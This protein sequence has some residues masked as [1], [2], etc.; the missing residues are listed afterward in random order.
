MH[1]YF[2]LTIGSFIVQIFKKILK[3]DPELLGCA[4]FW[5]KMVHLAQTIFF[6]G[7]VINI[8]FIYL[9]VPFIVQ[10]FKNIL[11]AN[12]EL[13]GCAIFGPKWPNCP[14]R[15]FFRKPVNKNIHAYLHAKNQSQI[16]IY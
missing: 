1:Y 4:I 5:P 8:I 7:K 9:L 6:C 10:N 11:K 14:M 13:S 3:A 16:L 15:I 12:P 2:H